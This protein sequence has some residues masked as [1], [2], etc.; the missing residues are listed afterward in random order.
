MRGVL[1][2]SDDKRNGKQDGRYV[3]SN[4]VAE[5]DLRTFFQTCYQGLGS[6]A[7]MQRSSVMKSGDDPNMMGEPPAR[8]A[9]LGIIRT[10]L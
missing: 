2:Q 10:L 3:L 8:T 9:E 7:S 6:G 5:P 1:R 4:G